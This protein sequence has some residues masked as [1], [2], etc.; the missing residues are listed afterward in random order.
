MFIS[1]ELFSHESE[2]RKIGTRSRGAR[3][4]QNELEVLALL[5]PFSNT[6]ILLDLIKR[7]S[8]QIHFN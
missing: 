2:F 7:V 6:N 8:N 4:R 3:E 5:G 1:L